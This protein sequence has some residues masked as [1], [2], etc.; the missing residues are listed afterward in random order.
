[1]NSN[2]DHGNR[3]FFEFGDTIIV[4]ENKFSDMTNFTICEKYVDDKGHIITREPIVNLDMSKDKITN[5]VLGLLKSINI[6]ACLYDIK[7]KQKNDGLFLKI[8]GRILETGSTVLL[9]NGDKKVIYDCLLDPYSNPR[10]WLIK[11]DNDRDRNWYTNDGYWKSR[12]IP[13]HRDIVEII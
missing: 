10:P 1:M 4:I 9:R 6:N 2:E 3:Y 7:S 5:L 13:D 12:I 8:K 11:F